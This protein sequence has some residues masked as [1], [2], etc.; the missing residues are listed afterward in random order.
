MS[1]SNDK[2]R[3]WE[4]NLLKLISEDNYEELS[5]IVNINIIDFDI[6]IGEKFNVKENKDDFYNDPSQ[7]SLNSNIGDTLTD[8]AIKNNKNKAAKALKELIEKKNKSNDNN[9]TDDITSKLRVLKT[10]SSVI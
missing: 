9:I 5:S 2:F 7:F 3:E 1:T 4:F 6:K 8:I 10:R